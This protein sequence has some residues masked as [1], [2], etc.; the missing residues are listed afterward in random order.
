MKKNINFVFPTADDIEFVKKLKDLQEIQRKMKDLFSQKFPMMVFPY[1]IFQKE[2]KSGN[3]IFCYC[4]GCPAKVNYEYVEEGLWIVK[5]FKNEHEHD[6][7]KPKAK[8]SQ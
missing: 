6:L 8:S 2:A 3:K 1:K 5:S 4:R 7:R